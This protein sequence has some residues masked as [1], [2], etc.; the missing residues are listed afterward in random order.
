LGRATGTNDEGRSIAAPAS[1]SITKGD[2]P[3]AS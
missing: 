3:Y 1:L 2:A